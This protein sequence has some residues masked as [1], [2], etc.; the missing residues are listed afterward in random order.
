MKL[1]E[2]KTFYADKKFKI[3]S[4]CGKCKRSILLEKMYIGHNGPYRFYFCTDCVRSIEEA[5]ENSKIKRPK[6]Y[7]K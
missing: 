2:K 7:K 6:M 5:E 1:K 3:Y 4:R